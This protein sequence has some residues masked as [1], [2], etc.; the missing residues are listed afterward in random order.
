MAKKQV[1]YP[2]TFRQ[3]LEKIAEARDGRAPSDAA[4]EAYMEKVFST[5]WHEFLGEGS[6]ALAHAMLNE[7]RHKLYFRYS[8]ELRRNSR[9]V[10]PAP[11]EKESPVPP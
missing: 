7:Q 11:W 10:V 5:F 1:R 2:R 8:M 9:I 3:K 4:N 6:V